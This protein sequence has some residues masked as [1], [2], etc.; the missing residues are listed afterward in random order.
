MQKPVFGRNDHHPIGVVSGPFDVPQMLTTVGTKREGERQ[1]KRVTHMF[2]VGNRLLAVL[3]RHIG[4]AKK[5]QQ[6]AEI[7]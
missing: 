3:A 5:P 1:R 2:R 6:I 4:T 7:G